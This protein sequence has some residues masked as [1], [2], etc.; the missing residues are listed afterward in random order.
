MTIFCSEAALVIIILTL[1]RCKYVGGELGGPTCIK[2][3][4]SALLTGL[5]VLYLVMSTLEV[6]HVLPAF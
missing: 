1:R 5:W 2:Y 4:T 6:Y 3:A